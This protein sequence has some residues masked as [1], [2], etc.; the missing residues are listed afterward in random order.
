MNDGD[1]S[2][3]GTR[4]LIDSFYNAY[5]TGGLDAMLQLMA[6]DAV[7]TFVGHGTFRGKAEIHPYMAW[8]A[9]QLPVLKFNVTAKIVDGDR[10]AVIWDETG[11]TKNGAEWAAVG[12]DTY[13]VVDGKI[14][15]LTCLGDT[16]K[17][18]R[19]LETYQKG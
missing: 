10:A 15:E 13:R 3:T 12:V 9:T 17:M 1:D 6:D 18:Q 19:L 2:T 8:A 7:V 5:L 16:E 4:A 11:T 14:V